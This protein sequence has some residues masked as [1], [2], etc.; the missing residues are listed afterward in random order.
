MSI[1]DACSGTVVEERTLIRNTDGASGSAC[2]SSQWSLST[3]AKGWVLAQ[4]AIKK[5]IEGIGII[6]ITGRS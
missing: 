3:E 6:D 5:Q 4:G 2:C 1:K